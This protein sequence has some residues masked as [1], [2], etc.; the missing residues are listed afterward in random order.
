[1]VSIA[2]LVV[3][4]ALA[5]PSPQDHGSVSSARA[6]FGH[7]LAAAGRKA[8]AGGHLGGDL[9]PQLRAACAQEEQIFRAAMINADMAAGT[10]RLDAEEAALLEIEDILANVISVVRDEAELSRGGVSR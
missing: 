2:A 5:G 1:M 4:G 7:C 6:A 9:E 10:K 8:L 3:M